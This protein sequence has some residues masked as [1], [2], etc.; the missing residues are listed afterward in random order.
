LEADAGISQDI[1]KAPRSK[2]KC[3]CCCAAAP[4]T[5][6]TPSVST[7]SYQLIDATNFSDPGCHPAVSTPMPTAAMNNTMINISAG[8]DVNGGGGCVGRVSGD[9]TEG[10]GGR[11][12]S[13]PPLSPKTQRYVN[14]EAQ[15]K[16]GMQT[17]RRLQSHVTALQRSAA[18]STQE[19]ERSS[20]RE[21]AL[22]AKL[23]MQR[24]Q[25]K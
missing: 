10:G 2:S 20:L 17:N 9:N 11:Q 19:A 24:S 8:C 12:I 22:K 23:E 25:R 6:L 18:K 5:T 21:Q 7:S 16:A 14:A 3:P 1:P 4:S 13:F 15:S